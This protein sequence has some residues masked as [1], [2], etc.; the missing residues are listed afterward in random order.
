[1]NLAETEIFIKRTLQGSRDGLMRKAAAEPD[2]TWRV[3]VTLNIVRLLISVT[4]LG[5][6]FVGTDPL[7]IFVG[8]APSW[9]GQP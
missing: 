6:F 5:L 4:L 1:M 2:L 8:N 3:I 7:S 9:A